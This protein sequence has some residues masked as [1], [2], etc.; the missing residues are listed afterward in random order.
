MADA[1]VN[2]RVSAVKELHHA[3]TQYGEDLRRALDS[4]RRDLT[5]SSARFQMA[6]IESERALLDAQ[7]RVE[8]ARATLTACRENCEGFQREYARAQIVEQEAARRHSANQSANA[9]F[10]R[11]EAD[12]RSSMTR[13]Q[14]SA[15][16]AVPR[17]CG[18]LSKHVELLSHYLQIGAI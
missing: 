4:A 11:I 12:L 6:V 16:E 14:H 7:R 5:A 3:V 8:S 15:D 2:A 17:T 1:P 18:E 10:K 9:A 13:I